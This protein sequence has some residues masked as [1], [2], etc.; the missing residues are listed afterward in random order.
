[1]CAPPDPPMILP[2]RFCFCPLILFQWANFAH[3]SQQKKTGPDKNIPGQNLT[4]SGCAFL[5]RTAKTWRP[6]VSAMVR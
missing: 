5:F 4:I 6:R 2:T 1:M 3:V